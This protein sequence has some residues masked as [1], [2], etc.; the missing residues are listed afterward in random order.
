MDPHQ[1]GDQDPAQGAPRSTVD[2]A[3]IAKFEAMAEAWWDPTGSFK[4]LHRLNPVRVQFIRDRLAHALGRDPTQ[5]LPLRGRSIL[6]IGCGGGLLAEPLARLGAT[7]TGVDAAERNIAIARDHAEKVGVKVT[8][9]PC[10]AEDLADQG[11][12]GGG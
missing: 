8:Y 1:T 3:E 4:P 7:V 9:L 5:P 2:H 12:P 10:T 6:D 11:G